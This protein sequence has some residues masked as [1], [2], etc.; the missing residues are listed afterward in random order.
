[1]SLGLL[2]DGA[3]DA[4]PLPNDISVI[5]ATFGDR[6]EWDPLAERAIESVAKQTMTPAEVTRVHAGSLHEARNQGAELATGRW[7]CFLDAD[8]ELDPGYLEAMS[9]ATKEHWHFHMAEEILFQP[10]TLGIVDGVED[11]APVVIP[12]TKLLECNYLVIGTLVRRDHFLRLG[13]FHAWPILEDW[14]FFIRCWLDGVTVVPV[15]G[16]VYRVHVRADG[17]NLQATH[18]RTYGA[19]RNRHI[20]AARALGLL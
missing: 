15:A 11:D 10:A 16:A 5:V 2:V 20:P 4:A 8:D 12:P 17:R 9:L 1:M 6:L 7:L 14:D 13:G 19:I 3:Q 18:N